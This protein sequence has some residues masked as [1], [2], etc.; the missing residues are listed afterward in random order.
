MRGLLSKGALHDIIALT[1]IIGCFILIAIGRNH[2][3]TYL[4]IAVVT[5]YGIGKGISSDIQ[6]H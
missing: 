6:G 5:A 1:T 3:V 2:L 4:L